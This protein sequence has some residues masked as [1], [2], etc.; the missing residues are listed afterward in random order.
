MGTISNGLTSPSTATFNGTSQYA[1]DLQQAINQA[2]AIA[3][4]PLTQLENNVSTLQS[5]SSELTSLQNDFTS[6]QTAIQQLSSS[7]GSGALAATVSDNTVASVSTDSAA[8]TPGTY[9][10]N[11][12]TPGSPTSTLSNTGLPT[13]TDPNQSS[14]SSSNSFTLTVGGSTYTVSPTANTLNGLAEAINA[15]NYGVSATILNIGPPSA[16][17]Y[18]LSLQSSTLGS[19]NIQLNDGTQNL[20]SVL[21][22]GA[23]AQYQ[24]DGQP[25]T[26]ISS[27]SSTVTLAPGVTV[28]LLKAGQTTVTV[29]PDSSAASSALSAFATAYNT[30]VSDLNNNHGTNGGPLTGQSVVLQLEQSLTSLLQYSGGSGNVTGLADI[31]LTFNSQGQLTFDQATFDNAQSTNPQAVASF[32]GSATGGGFLQ[33]ATN[34]LSGLENTTS[35][36]FTQT[37]NS[38]QQQ[39]NADNSE[40]T[41]TQ[42]RIANMQNSLTAQ[43]TQADAMIASLESQQTYYTTLFSDTQNAIQ[44][45]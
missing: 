16:P 35:G 3:S 42:T 6:L 37:Q 19:E 14:I 38:Y 18:R 36:V 23:P 10:L 20:L 13:V 22:D 17:D 4:I 30:A 33:S 34:L 27:D 9:Q 41:D 40:I 43:M 24:V 7:S 5:Q 15:G 11:V 28:D 12:I 21:S 39:V 32:L 2:V 1:G 8:S 29:A 25:S 45:G 26:P 44:N 31:G